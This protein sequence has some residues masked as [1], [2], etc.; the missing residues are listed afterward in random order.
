MKIW[1]A[2]V[3]IVTTTMKLLSAVKVYTLVAERATG[4]KM[5]KD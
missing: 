1:C 3:S 4:T 2:R 5:Q